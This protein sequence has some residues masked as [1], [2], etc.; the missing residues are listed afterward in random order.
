MTSPAVTYPGGDGMRR[1]TLRHSTD[2]PLPDSPTMPSVLPFETASDTAALAKTVAPRIRNSVT[3]PR[4]S[5]TGPEVGAGR[6]GAVPAP[7]RP[8]STLDTLERFGS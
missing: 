6:G 4:T 8:I 2:F 1:S 7:P 5:R 3:S